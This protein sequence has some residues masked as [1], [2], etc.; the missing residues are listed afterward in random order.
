M[1]DKRLENRKKFFDPVVDK[2]SEREKFMVSLRK[3]HKQEMFMKKRQLYYQQSINQTPQTSTSSDM[4][5]DDD[6]I[7]FVSFKESMVNIDSRLYSDS[8]SI[9]DTICILK[10]NLLSENMT[11]NF[12]RMN[13]SYLRRMIGE[14]PE[15]V[16]PVFYEESLMNVVFEFM[17]KTLD[18]RRYVTEITWILSG[19]FST[20]ELKIATHFADSKY[21]VMSYV[22]DVLEKYQTD[23]CI[24]SNLIYLWSN[25]ALEPTIRDDIF[26]TNFIAV[27][28]EI[29]TREHVQNVMAANIVWCM[30]WFTSKKIPQNFTTIFLEIASYLIY[31]KD[32]KVVKDVLIFIKEIGDRNDDIGFDWNQYGLIDKIS[33]LVLDGSE[34]PDLREKYN[35]KTN[36]LHALCAISYTNDA[37]TISDLLENGI[38]DT[39]MNACEEDENENLQKILFII[40]NIAVTGKLYALE[41]YKST[42]FGHAFDCISLEDTDFS[43]MQEAINLII[44]VFQRVPE[45][46]KVEI[47]EQ[48]EKFLNPIVDLISRAS[49]EKLKVN[50]LEALE[51]MFEIWQQRSA[52]EFSHGLSPDRSM[53]DNFI[54]SFTN[55]GGPEII[56]A[57]LNDENR[58]VMNHWCNIAKFLEVEMAEVREM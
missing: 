28:K 6:T 26:Y 52:K 47:L 38:L 34:Q 57:L 24:V 13:L 10:E 7:N 42:I 9:V 32:L 14:D 50:I 37:G 45:E 35:I 17:M 5:K 31:H 55:A 3:K 27:L 23:S 11:D 33:S 22:H 21:K 39:L 2:R 41:V 4:E 18:D 43:V 58:D 51:N 1:E 25:Y 16:I 48:D 40:S 20:E 29:G 53:L 19:L 30:T 56:D 12:Y 46:I 15:N 36:C 54:D 8:I 49:S 44:T